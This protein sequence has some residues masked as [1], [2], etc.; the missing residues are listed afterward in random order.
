MKYALLLL[1]LLIGCVGSEVPAEENKTEN[2][3]VKEP[4][5]PQRFTTVDY[6]FLYPNDMVLQDSENFFA[7]NMLPDKVGESFTLESSSVASLYGPNKEKLF[8]EDSGEAPVEILGDFT[9]GKNVTFIEYSTFSID[10]STHGA[11]V[12]Y[13]KRQDGF[14]YN[15][16]LMSLYVPEKSLI[17]NIDI[18]G[19][20]PRKVRDIRQEFIL[21]F[22]LE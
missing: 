4:P 8:L 17:I 7:L 18:Y 6:T 14:L 10:R 2:V 12:T 13:T 9:E 5:S 15:G 19:I 3:T 20:D 1:I 11:Q 16:Y 21:S 22:R